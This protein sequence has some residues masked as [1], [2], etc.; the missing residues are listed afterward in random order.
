MR[1]IHLADLHFGKSIHGVSLLENGDQDFWVE[2]FLELAEER[3]PDAVVIAGDVYDR[4]A[5]SGDAVQLLSRM[6][7]R[8]S[9]LHIPVMMTAGN[10]DSVQRLSFAD[11]MLA[12]EGLHISAPL[13]DTDRL[14][15]V[16]LQDAFGPV[17]FWLMPYVYPALIARALGDDS[18][19]EYDAAVRALLERQ[20]VDFTQR[21]VLIAHQNVT[22]NGV[23]AGRGGSES[24]VGGVGQIDYTVFDGFDYAALG[25][26]H[27]ACPVGRESVRYAGSPLCYHF[28]ETRQ[29]AKGPVWVELGAKGEAPQT[30]TLHIPPLHPMR[31]LCGAYEE[32][33]DQELQNPRGGE[34]LRLVLTDRR[35]SPEISAFFDELFRSRG[36]ILMDRCSTFD[37]FRGDAG[38]PSVRAVEQ[39][40]IRKLF[41]DFYAERSGG[42][43]PDEEEL[44]LLACAEELTQRAQVHGAPTAADVDRLLAFLMRQEVRQ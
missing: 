13:F 27:A 5:P 43:S 11:A 6:L 21:N 10:H 33:R 24:T 29:P 37:P 40:S 17:T 41:R 36:S 2:R 4:S 20:D 15:R 39:K 23:E 44:A 9:A 19:R 38:A 31:E 1:F 30:E 42:D 34:Y 32:L 26:I 8:L 22:A 35:L 28:N 25:H 12:R 7:T 14:V 3:R 18:L 16:T